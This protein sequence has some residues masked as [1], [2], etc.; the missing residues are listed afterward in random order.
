VAAILP[1]LGAVGYLIQRVYL[2]T[3]RQVRIMDLEAK[4]PLCTHFLESLA[5]IVTIR[6]FGWLSAYREKNNRFLLRS[7]VPFYLLF[8]IQN[9]LTLVLQLVVAG[10]IT[11]IVGLAVGLRSK[12]DTGYLGLALVAAVRIPILQMRRQLNLN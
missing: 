12:V 8:A 3:S 10:L 9:W 5:G 7:Q 6:C 1:L 11:C 2:R 4:A